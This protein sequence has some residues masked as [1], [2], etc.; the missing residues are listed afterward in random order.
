M[1]LQ[2]N[3]VYVGIK[4]E[5]EDQGRKLALG[6]PGLADIFKGGVETN[7]SSERRVA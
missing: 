5:T 1:C 2:V 6:S 7:D 3:G 4:V